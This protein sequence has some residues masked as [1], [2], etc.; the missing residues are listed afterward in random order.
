M[1]AIVRRPVI[2]LVTHV[3]Q[4]PAAER[5][6]FATRLHSD[7]GAR[8]LIVETCHRVEAYTTS[9]GGP[10]ASV[11]A[12]V[13]TGGRVLEGPDAVRHAVSVATGRDSIVLGED[14]V[15]HQ[16]RG[17]LAAARTSGVLDPE[18]ERLFALALQA[19]RRAR[20]WRSGRQRSLADVAVDTVERASG[21]VRGTEALV[22]GAGRMGGLMV[23]AA[24]AA[25]ASVT[26]A[27]R[28]T[29]RAR[30]LTS[31]TGGRTSALDPG[32]EV[33]RFGAIFV[34][35]GGP[36]AIDGSTVAALL[37]RGPIVVD[38]SVPA[39][40]PA[41]LAAGLGSRLVSADALA[42][43][44]AEEARRDRELDPRLD[45]LIDATVESYVE[46]QARGDARAAAD[47]LLRRA[48]LDRE[49]ELA[50]LWRRLPTLEPEARE[51]I[52]G[53]TRHL[54]A[55]LLRQPLERLGR[56]PD[57]TDERSVRDLFA[58]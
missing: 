37:D 38:L 41:A 23:R 16:L 9:V 19:G 2:A 30:A 21:P 6:R 56:D 12:A 54:A 33:G 44:E 40:V 53:M 22:V 39:A 10:A 3:R 17:S 29:D 7:R 58:L 13:P 48:D 15:L 46:W 49:A 28:S 4:V 57:G 31:A 1:S 11:V 55:R 5:Q 51:A 36:W 35:L 8:L 27:N 26:V 45:G 14:Q 43:R 32:S 47:A 20:S 25:G 18:I 34:A 52:E 24:A 42:L 50:A